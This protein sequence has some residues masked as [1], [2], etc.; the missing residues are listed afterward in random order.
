LQAKDG[1]V[2]IGAIVCKL[3]PHK[4]TLRK[5]GYIA[6]LAIDHSYR[7]KGIG[8]SINITYHQSF[9]CVAVGLILEN[10]TFN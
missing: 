7:R 9:K 10:Y 6:M 5:R 1:S 2:T 4:R 3:D 8:E